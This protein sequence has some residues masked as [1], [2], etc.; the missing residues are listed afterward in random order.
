MSRINILSK[1][2][3]QNYESRPEIIEREWLNIIK[4]V[5]NGDEYFS[6]L[7]LPDTKVIYVVQYGDISS[8]PKGCTQSRPLIEMT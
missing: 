4:E 5:Q 3:I 2:D 7:R 8:I 1:A 6:N